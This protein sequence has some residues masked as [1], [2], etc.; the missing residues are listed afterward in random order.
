ME[1]KINEDELAHLVFLFGNSRQKKEA[2]SLFL[3]ST[4]TISKYGM[5]KLSLLIIIYCSYMNRYFSFG[6]L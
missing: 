6:S 2:V 4:V 5:Q 1:G 3:G